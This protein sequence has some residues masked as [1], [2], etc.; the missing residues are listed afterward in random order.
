MKKI[1]I[2]WIQQILYSSIS[3][4]IYSIEMLECLSRH[5]ATLNIMLI[6]GADFY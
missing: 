4:I 6:A 2:F 1:E 5:E 3:R